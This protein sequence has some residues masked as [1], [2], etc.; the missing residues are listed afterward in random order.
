MVQGES[1]TVDSNTSV[2]H[3]GLSRADAARFS[4]KWKTATDEKQQSQAFWHSFFMDVLKISDLQDAG[5]EFEK[6]VISAIPLSTSDR[7]HR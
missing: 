4:E 1:S 5:I 3:T 2:E 6:R 7:F